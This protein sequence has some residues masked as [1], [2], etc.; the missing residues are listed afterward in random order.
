M[1]RAIVT[2]SGGFS[3]SRLKQ[4]LESQGVV[5]H[6]LR[7]SPLT[8][9]ASLKSVFEEAK[10]DAVFHL[11]GVTVSSELSEYYRGNVLYA[12]LILSA[13]G[14]RKDCPVLFVGTAAEYGPVDLLP[15]SESAPCRPYNH[16][17]TSKLAQTELARRASEE[18]YRVVVAR[19]FNV[20]GPRMPRHLFLGEVL[21]QLRTRPES[22]RL[23]NLSS[24]RDFVDVEDLVVIYKRLVEE[25][26]AY[27][28]IVNICTGK[29]TS[30]RS[31]VETV[32][33]RLAPQ[34]RIEMDPAR[35][36]RFEV[37]EHYGDPSLLKSLFP[38]FHFRSIDETL[39][40]VCREAAVES[41]AA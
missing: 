41:E 20:L 8:D 28:R 32:V 2:G 5:V 17:G 4:Y 24:T 34:T 19:P 33:A 35:K 6:P 9:V 11:G 36:K 13:L 26:K 12:A 23:G 29:P 15:I 39:N 1:K 18:G 37:P 40:R 21:H 14:D 10:P 25:P 16:Y 7:L 38:D 30:I 3:G 27:G 22:L 31:L